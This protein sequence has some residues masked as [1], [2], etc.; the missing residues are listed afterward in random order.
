[1][2]KKTRWDDEGFVSFPGFARECVT[3]RLCLHC[4]D[5][6]QLVAGRSPEARI[7]RRPQ[8]PGKTD[9]VLAMTIKFATLVLSLALMITATFGLGFEAQAADASMTKLSTMPV[10][11]GAKTV[12]AVV[13]NDD[14]S[15]REGLLTWDSITED[16]GMLLDFVLPAEYAIHMQGMKFPIDAV[17]IDVNGVIKLIYEDI[18]PNSRQIYYSLFPCRYCLELKAGFCK[19]YGVKI[20][21][22]VVFGSSAAR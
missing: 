20:G 10:T 15:R 12:T 9:T 1:V 18:R 8:E 5:E 13:A 19:K 14:R 22:T 16:Q 6:L 17:W 7:P 2:I 11:L 4:T 3:W 21:Q